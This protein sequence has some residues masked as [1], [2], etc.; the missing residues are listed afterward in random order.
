MVDVTVLYYTANVESEIFEQRVRDIIWQNKGDLPLV[1]VSQKPI[2]FGLNICVGVHPVC[3]ANEFRQ[4]QIGLKEV[5]TQYVLTAEADTL[6]PPSY[7][8][9]RPERLGKFYRYDNVWVGYYKNTTDTKP[10]YHFK[11]F[12]DGSQLIDRDL[13]LYILD[14]VLEGK[15]TWSTPDVKIGKVYGKTRKNYT[16]TGDPVITFKTRNNVSANTKTQGYPKRK[17]PYWGKM[18]DLR[19][20][21]FG[22]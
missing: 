22:D 9:Y 21:I 7:F 11:G 1:S 12:S 4:I 10:K 3:Y 17:L 2:D 19:E 16:W 18:L 6:Y 5:K 14:G 8:N 13:W 15:D 20:R